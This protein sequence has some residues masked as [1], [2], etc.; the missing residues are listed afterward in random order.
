MN[1]D[2]KTQDALAHVQALRGEKQELP[3]T[4]ASP[5]ESVAPPPVIQPPPP[6]VLASPQVAPPQT[7]TPP[8]PAAMPLSPEQIQFLTTIGLPLSMQQ[9][10]WLQAQYPLLQVLSQNQLSALGIGIT[11]PPPPTV[12]SPVPQPVLAPRQA[13]ISLYQQFEAQAQNATVSQVDTVNK[14]KRSINFG[15]IGTGQGGS[16]IAEAFHQLGYPVCVVNTAEHDLRNI[17]IPEDNKLLL[18]IGAGGAGKDLEEGLGAATDYA[19][20]ILDLMKNSFGRK[21]DHILVCCGGGGGSGS[22]SLPKVIDMA[23]I[24]GVPVGVIFT[25]PKNAEGS[26]VK[27]N[28]LNRLLMLNNKLQS[29]DIA[30]LILVDNNKIHEMHTGAS[31]AKFWRIA[32][33]QIAGLFHLFNVLSAQNSAYTSL[34]PADYKTIIN[35]KGCIIFGSTVVEDASRKTAVAKALRE[36]IAKGL[37]AEGFD[38]T[39]SNIAGMILTGSQ[40][41]MENLPQENLDAAIEC[42]ERIVGSGTL[43]HGIY[44][45][46]V[47]KLTV[48][49][50]IGGL[51]LPHERIEAMLK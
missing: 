46:N 12:P 49:T 5:P 4:F 13:G 38:L 39:Q 2:K 30:P 47:D 26:K 16:R 40:E 50:I 9:F 8:P 10:Q 44:N 31:L 24:M 48:Y 21:V 23:R 32:N 6:P 19:E 45:E 29:G 7:Y 20:D 25:L 34:D 18:K 35:S 37:L 14:E 28:T 11:A 3:L 43:H 15:I 33:A 41:L 42:L 36:N 27:S 1:D 17:N 51:E 22:G